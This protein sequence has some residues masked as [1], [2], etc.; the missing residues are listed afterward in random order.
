[1][2]CRQWTATMTWIL[3]SSLPRWPPGHTASC[4]SLD[5]HH[6]AWSHP[7]WQY[8]FCPRVHTQQQERHQSYHDLGQ[9][10]HE[11]F[12]SLPLLW[13]LWWWWKFVQQLVLWWWWS[14]WPLAHRQWTYISQFPPP[15]V[16]PTA[17][18]PWQ[19]CRGRS[20]SAGSVCRTSGWPRSASWRSTC[21]AYPARLR[22]SPGTCPGP[23][24]GLS[25]IVLE[26]E[27]LF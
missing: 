6:S 16:T 19:W 4:D 11:R 5:L 7:L 23:Q 24:R 17:S 20:C 27:K 26:R 18:G 25:N 14:S 3:P 8:H 2:S 9:V 15:S 1:M 13:K 12:A 10:S 21:P 22:W